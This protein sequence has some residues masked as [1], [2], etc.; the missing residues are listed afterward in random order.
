MFGNFFSKK[1]NLLAKTRVQIE[2]GQ[3]IWFRDSD[4]QLWALCTSA[5]DF[6]FSLWRKIILS[7][8]FS[9][10]SIKYLCKYYLGCLLMQIP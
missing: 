9:E 6:S 8:C 4:A 10:W 3:K 2:A 5:I 1:V 7:Q